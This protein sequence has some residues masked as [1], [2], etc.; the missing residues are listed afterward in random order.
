MFEADQRPQGRSRIVWVTEREGLGLG[1]QSGQ[2]LIKNRPF[3]IYPLGS[4]ADLACVGKARPADA[5]NG[6]LK[7]AVGKNNGR[8]FPSQ[9][10][11]DIPH[12]HGRALHNGLARDGL[13]RKRNGVNT[14]MADQ[15]FSGRVRPKPVHDIIDTVRHA[16]LVHHLA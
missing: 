7:V 13:S 2:K 3:N 4:Q 8:V 11:R 5:L 10:K 14:R 16:G 9:L 12:A 15:E 1:F 6:R